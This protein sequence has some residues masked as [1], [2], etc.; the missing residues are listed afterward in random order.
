MKKHLVASAAVLAMA[1]P[2][3]ATAD[4]NYSFVE[5][6]Y[7]LF[8]DDDDTNAYRLK[9]SFAITDNIF[10]LGDYT[11]FDLDEGDFDTVSLGVGYRHGI[12][13]QLDLYGAL[14]IE[15]VDADIDDDTGLG[16]RAGAR[17][18]VM[19]QLELKGE[20]H[21]INDVFEEDTT[22]VTLGGQ[23]LFTPAIGAVLEYTADTDSDGDNA[24]ILGGRF[25]F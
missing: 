12:N 2:F 16:L 4:I 13:E 17:F 9:G 18:M 25:N 14:S 21:H 15:Y 3:A 11:T 22:L 24:I 5:L 23:F 8:D 19:P 6:D 1:M 10:I 7:I 20:L